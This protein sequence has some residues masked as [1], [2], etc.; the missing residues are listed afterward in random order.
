[1]TRS[2]HLQRDEL[3]YAKWLSVGSRLSFL[4]L[5]CTFAVYVSGV[6]PP[7]L[8]VAD[9][10]KV[11]GLSAAQYL[12]ATGAPKGW[13]WVGRLGSSDIMN[14]I[15]VACIALVTP[16][17]YLRALPEFVMRRDW[18]F[19]TI[20]ALELLIFGFAASSLATG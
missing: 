5:V 15:G 7:S 18:P 2:E 8:S 17:C 1:M 4:V 13:E 11:W 9:L 20:A 10:P 14:F 16:V 6:V 19:A 3:I 12:A